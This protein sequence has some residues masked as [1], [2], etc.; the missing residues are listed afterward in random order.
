MGGIFILRG[1]KKLIEMAEQQY[2]SESILQELLQEYPQLLAGQ[3]IDS[4]NPRRWLLVCREAG[5]PDGIGA[6]D[7][8]ATD[9]LFIDQ[10]GVPT[11]VEVKRSTDTRIRMEVV[12]QILDYASNAVAY[13]P[14]EKIKS[15]YEKTCEDKQVDPIQCLIEFLGSNDEP[16]LFWSQ[17]K[18]NLQAGKIR[19]LFVADE[20]PNELQRIV[21][22]LNEQMDPAEILAIEIKQFAGDELKTLVPRVIGLTSEAKRRKGTEVLTKQ[23]DENSFIGKLN[24]NQ[25]KVARKLL[26]WSKLEMSRI[27]WGKGKIDGS[28][29]PILDHKGVDYF[30]IAVRTGY[31]DNPHIQVQFDPLSKRPPFDDESLRLEFMS[32]LNEIPEV[33]LPEDSV[34]RYPGIPFSLLANDSSFQKLIEALEWLVQ[35]VKFHN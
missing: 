8:W 11:I 27:W 34:S 22:F 14:I 10:D 17:V 30:P 33:N 16:E 19:M 6:G 26:E 15:M 1:D 24:D 18:T 25:A 7:R 32:R 20:I 3:Q 28:F 23:W 12:G 9:H 21:E 5:I 31:K 13:W 29:I 2:E 35:K 4:G